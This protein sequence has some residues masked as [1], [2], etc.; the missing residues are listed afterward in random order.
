MEYD[1]FDSSKLC[2]ISLLENNDIVF[3]QENDIR[4]RSVVIISN[5]NEKNEVISSTN[6][7]NCVDCG[8][9]VSVHSDRCAMCG[10]LL[11]HTVK[12]YYNVL[13]DKLIAERKIKECELLIA[14]QNLHSCM[15][16][17]CKL[18][19]RTQSEKMILIEQI[20]AYAVEEK[21]ENLML[22]SISKLK[23]L[24]TRERTE[25][26]EKI[27]QEIRDLL[28]KA[29]IDISLCEPE[30]ILEIHK[31]CVND[32]IKKLIEKQKKDAE[33]LFFVIVEELFSEIDNNL[34][35]EYRKITEEDLYLSYK[36][37]LRLN[38][39]EGLYSNRNATSGGGDEPVKLADFNLMR[40][41]AYKISEYIKTLQNKAYRADN[42]DE[43][44]QIYDEYIKILQLTN[45]RN[46]QAELRHYCV[47]CIAYP[48][49]ADYGGELRK[50]LDI[51]AQ[52]VFEV[53]EDRRGQEKI[54]CKNDT[55]IASE[56]TEKDL[57]Y[58]KVKSIVVK[59][60]YK[61]ENSSPEQF[62][63]LNVLHCKNQN[64]YYF[65]V[66]ELPRL[67]KLG[68]L[69]CKIYTDET[70]TGNSATLN[71]ESLLK[72]CGYN[73]QASQNLSADERRR[74]LVGVI[75]NGIYSYENVILF[76]KRLIYIRNCMKQKDMSNAISKWQDDI[77]YLERNRQ[78]FRTYF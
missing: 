63:L 50:I 16:E 73:V 62:T 54:I 52:Y 29:G 30:D 47:Y 72:K 78:W 75:Q 66:K 24:L 32:G 69:Q 38:E 14:R 61:Q 43:Y 44:R 23:E 12:T 13:I 15:V 46:R 70:F 26:S 58:Y 76:L 45:C 39:E 74:I 77:R 57:Q 34:K 17:L 20:K 59:I 19:F 7:I 28:R 31:Q 27:P 6:M 18:A 65:N 49:L 21:E 55:L 36:R 1:F 35:E 11:A 37:F 41:I 68:K 9:Y 48:L 71:E 25:L 51:P 5:E 2:G 60:K 40:K 22:L 8:H 67:L 42:N 4:G 10:C 53:K 64:V 56:K 33:I 3:E